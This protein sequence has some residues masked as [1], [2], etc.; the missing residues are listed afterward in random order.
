MELARRFLRV[1]C[2]PKSKCSPHP[3]RNLPESHQFTSYHVRSPVESYFVFN[4]LKNSVSVG[5][6]KPGHGQGSVTRRCLRSNDKYLQVNYYNNNDNVNCVCN[7]FLKVLTCFIYH[8]W[9]FKC[10]ISFPQAP[11]HWKA[12]RDSGWETFAR[13]E[14]EGVCLC[15]FFSDIIAKPKS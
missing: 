12:D 4:Q 6:V 14:R 9:T 8:L 7:A 13:T 10:Q 5:G 2:C 3:N 1:L 11:I 15:V